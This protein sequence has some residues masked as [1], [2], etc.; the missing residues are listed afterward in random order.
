MSR[1]ICR[2]ILIKKF[3]HLVPF[4]D[5]LYKRANKVLAI[6]EDGQPEE[7]LQVEGF[8]QGCPLSAIFAALV[9]GELVKEVE[10]RHQKK[11]RRRQHSLDNGDT[12]LLSYIDDANIVLRYDDAL[13]ILMTIRSIGKEFG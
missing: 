11:V 13:W 12:S 2:C 8:A 7:F 3:P 6:N 10:A 9:L 1:E 5:S 4:F